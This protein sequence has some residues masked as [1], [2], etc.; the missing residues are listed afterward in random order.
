MR[1]RLFLTATLAIL[2]LAGA[3]RS[4]PLLSPM[5]QDHAVLQR[6][7]PIRVWGQAPAGAS[8]AVDLSGQ[9]VTAVADS[10]GRWSAALPPRAAGGALVLTARTGD[11]VQSVG[12]LVMGDVWLC[13]GQSNMELPLRRGMNGESETGGAA[14]P[15]IRLLQTG[16]TSR[17][18]PTHALPPEAAWRVAS[19][20]S[21][22]DFSAACFFMGRNI[23]KTTGVPVGLIDATWGGS[24]IQDWISRPALRALG[25]YDEGLDVLA[26]YGRSQAA[27]M[28][29]WSAQLER[30]AAGIDPQGAAWRRPDFDDQAWATLPAEGFWE[31]VPALVGFD[32]VVWLRAEVTLT[33]AQ[34]A[35][36]ATLAL[37]PVD[38]I[39]TTFVN[40][41]EV[42]SREGWNRP[43]D[44][45]LA[46]GV[47]KAGRNVVALRVIDTGGGGGAW[48][49]AAEKVLK[50]ADGSTVSLGGTWRYRVS[51]P[52]GV[53]GAPPH[54]P[55]LGSSGLSTLHNGMIAPLAPFSLRGV[56]WYQGES[57]TAEASEYTRL[58]PAM[59]ADWRQ[60]FGDAELPFLIVQLANFG[61]QMSGPAESGWAAVRDVQRRVAA[62]DAKV[63]LASAIDLGDIYDI[64]PTNK[65]QVGVRLALLARKLAHGE[66]TL[67]AAG[68]A[69]VSAR[70][71]GGVVV[72]AF[73]QPLVVHGDARPTGMELC[74]AAACRFVDAEVAGTTVRLNVPAGFTPVKARHAWADSPIVNLYGAQALPATPFELRLD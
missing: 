27:G 56:A 3:A 74:D 6:D 71:E 10:E 66:S 34:A 69:P 64:H 1:H 70:R 72:V 9:A 47:L 31:G 38:D 28:A 35:Q 23:K 13:S 12:D 52:L 63:G 54:A 7:R 30:W 68:P 26:E 44:Y 37:G 33:K 20:Q 8:V 16:R 4:E 45:P 36:G 57:N 5:F 48:G 67:V 41:V 62:A 19:P 29:K 58:L 40:G 46:R 55:W 73:D 2:A 39:D 43:R 24:I 42:G 59:I 51:A 60:A 53:T 61:P 65:Q 49:P 21:A 50:L 15:D 11:Q 17:P 14:D 22:S 32:G 18:T 25:G